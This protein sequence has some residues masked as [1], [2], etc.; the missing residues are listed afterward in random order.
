MTWLALSI[1]LLVTAA[2][3]AHTQQAA[4]TSAIRIH[5]DATEAPRRV[6]HARLVIPADEG[7]LTLVY[8]KWIPGTHGPTGPV[9]DLAGLKLTVA[10]RSLPWKRDDL[11]M[12]AIHCDVPPGGDLT[13][14]LDFLVSPASPTAFEE[15]CASA[16]LAVISWGQ[17]LVYP[18]GPSMRDL[19]FEAEI[20]LPAG[21]SLATALP[22]K[23]RSGGR[24]AFAAVSLETLIDSPVLC[25]AHFKS[26][27]LGPTGGPP[28]FLHI[29][30]DSPEGLELEPSLEGKLDHLVAEGPALFGSRPYASYHFLLALSD[31]IAHFGLEH[32]ESSDNRA[33]ERTL[34]DEEAFLSNAELLPHEYA[35]CWNGKYRRPADMVTH[36]FQQPQR[37]R[38]L[39]IYE[40]LTDY[41]GMV[42]TA[43]S[44]LCTP[45]T[46]RDELALCAES[47]LNAR[48][49]TWRALEDTTAA[50]QLLYTARPEGAAWRRSAWD[51]YLEGALL[52]L[53]VDTIIRQRSNGQR[54]LDDFCRRFCGG[55]DGTPAVRPY[56][57]DDVVADLNA[58][59][60][61]DW[62][63][64]LTQRVS[65][66]SPEAPLAGIERAGWRLAYCETQSRIQE[67]WSRAW[68]EAVDL[69][70][71]I[72]IMIK[73]DGTVLDVV[74]GKA[75]DLADV[76]PGMK[77]VAVNTRRFSP[78]VLRTAIAATNEP[79]GRLV[80]LVENAEFFRTCSLDYKGGE[81]YPCLQRDP[82]RPDLLAEIIRPLTAARPPG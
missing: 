1:A 74:P 56:T 48:G 13:V 6:L 51:F 80:L 65:S 64:L 46:F 79:G 35:H 15:A 20:T 22:V 82:S 19:L 27:P 68:L 41:L 21:W 10:G 38:L 40:G 78:D 71:S 59:A 16:R 67:A 52:W 28:H 11:D 66:T 77:I 57:F 8:P 4:D 18:Q 55:A 72:G 69:T 33:P 53:E 34:L 76:A 12:Y 62:A 60:P 17:V 54:S 29:A 75:A 30:C 7:P 43:R 73:D 23:A 31:H 26:V 61:Y 2:A 9:T 58:V 70:A 50:A 42:L 39:W 45:E 44:G 24:T 5:V 63:T 14:E 3:L 47:A 49:R 32:H 36:D 81:K 37:T 25:G